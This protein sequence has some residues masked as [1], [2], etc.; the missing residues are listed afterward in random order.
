MLVSKHIIHVIDDKSGLLLNE[1]EGVSNLELDRFII[2]QIRKIIKSDF[3]R[4]AKFNN[5]EE[6]VVK[7]CCENILTIEKNNKV[8]LENSKVIA[9]YLYEKM[10]QVNKV[11]SC[12]LLITY[13]LEKDQKYIAILKLDYKKLH[14][15]KI[16]MIDEKLNIQIVENEIAINSNSCV[17]QAAIIGINNILDEEYNLRVYD[18]EAEKKKSYSNFMLMFLDIK[19]VKDHK[20]QTIDFE[21][22]VKEW[23]N[24]CVPDV[25]VAKEIRNLRNHMLLNNSVFDIEKFI[26]TSLSKYKLDES[27]RDFCYEKEI[28][29][30]FNIDKKYIEKKLKNRTLKTDTGFNITASRYD[31]DD[32][33]KFQIVKNES[34][35]YDIVIKN[36]LYHE[37]K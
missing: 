12:D 36:V 21:K 11:E 4:K 5:F 6:N 29:E 31:F 18:V 16:E 35:S 10:K 15:H 25:G 14:N 27:F 19:K 8:F 28:Y 30:D 34:G 13:L 24:N 9:A 22:Y 37:E 17:T 33:V 23:I 20:V 2:K 1:Y 7:N 32:R 3:L 26:E